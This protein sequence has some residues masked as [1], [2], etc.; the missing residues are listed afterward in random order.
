[1]QYS[2]HTDNLNRAIAFEVNQKDV[3]RFGGLAPLMNRARRS[4]VP[5]A[6][7]RVIDKYTPRDH[8]N[9]VYDTEDLI[10]QVLASLAAGMPDFND[11]EH[12]SM[13]KSFVSALRISN[14]ASAPTL[15]RFFARFEEKCKHD[16]M[17]ALAEVKGVHSRLTKTDPLRITTPAIMDLI[18]FTE[19]EA[20]R[21]LKK[22][23]DKEYFIIDVDSTPVELFGNQN[24][25]CYDGHYRC[26]SYLPIFVAINGVP[27]FV[28]N[29]PGAANGAALC[30]IHIR[31]L[32][33]KLR[34]S[35]PGA[36]ILV[37]GDT[38]YNNAE[39]IRIIVEE[40]V[41]Y[42]LGYNVRPK[43]LRTKLFRHIA[44]EYSSDPNSR[45]CMAKEI[46]KEIP[47][48]GL[49][50]EVKPPKRRR[51]LTSTTAG[52]KFRCC[53]FFHNYQ[54]KTWKTPRTVVCRL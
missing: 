48:T 45:I 40:G 25:A 38:G 52:N 31:R 32:I 49:F 26:I 5:A 18:D 4:G 17:M 13:D 14:A 51:K 2:N 41:S 7:A 10:N 30:L 33:Q 24:E 36:R 1:M 12:L 6:L 47:L 29:A 27:A 39:L 9:F 50:D 22:R 28:Q 53:S 43:D 15:S 23:G 37:R 21:I 46:L 34:E 19:N 3:T 44:E 8:F 35:F 11:V 20:I 54:A 16:R 42:I